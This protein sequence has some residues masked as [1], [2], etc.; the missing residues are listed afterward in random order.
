VE[1]TSH[2][3][4]LEGE[5]AENVGFLKVDSL[6]TLAP[7]ITEATMPPIPGG[8]TFANLFDPHGIAVTTGILNGGPV[9][10]V[11]DGGR[12]WVARVDLAKVFT[13]PGPAL[14]DTDFATAVTFLDART[15]A[16]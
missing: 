8:G 9:G 6:A 12:Q 2:I 7:A 5:N 15:P 4:F 16:P 1:P 3:A 14:A 11:V 10:F 13:L